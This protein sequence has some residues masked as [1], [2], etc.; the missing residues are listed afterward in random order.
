M[1]GR[2]NKERRV[3]VLALAPFDD[4]EESSLVGLLEV[5]QPYEEHHDYEEADH[6]ARVNHQLSSSSIAETFGSPIAHE[7]NCRS[8]GYQLN[9]G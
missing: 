9:G 6:G 3:L 8:G 2:L 7:R 4:S 5:D 1:S